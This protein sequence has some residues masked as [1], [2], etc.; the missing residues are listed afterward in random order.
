[1]RHELKKYIKYLF[2]FLF[3]VISF[4]SCSKN[5]V[6]ELE[7]VNLFSLNYGN[8]DDELNL[9]DLS[10]FLIYTPPY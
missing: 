5:K 6:S 10:N 4:I 9:F 3:T 7:R 1:M 8:F 2:V